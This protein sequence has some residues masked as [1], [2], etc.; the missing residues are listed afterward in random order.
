MKEISN[1]PV[2][3]LPGSVHEMDPGTT[4]DEHPGRPAARRVQGETDSF[5]CEYHNLCAECLIELA[6]HR[7]MARAGTCEWCKK[8][9][10]DLR[11]ARDYDEGLYGRVYRVCGGCIKRR[12]DEARAELDD[13]DD[14]ADYERD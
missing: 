7:A 8:V 12:D 11:D 9:A 3:T 6:N 4:C 1:G 10:T 13:D 14:W 2:S 5:G